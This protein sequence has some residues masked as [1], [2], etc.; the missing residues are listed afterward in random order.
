LLFPLELEEKKGSR[1]LSSDIKGRKKRIIIEKIEMQRKLLPTERGT[2][3]LYSLFLG[4]GRKK[5]G[6]IVIYLCLK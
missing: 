5:N 6:E 1:K 2:R 3:N 4:E